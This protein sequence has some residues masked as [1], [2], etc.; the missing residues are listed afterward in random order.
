MGKRMQSKVVTV[1][2]MTDDELDGLMSLIGAYLMSRDYVPLLHTRKMIHYV[3]AILQRKRRACIGLFVPVGPV[4]PGVAFSVGG[5]KPRTPQAIV[6]VTDLP[7]GLGVDGGPST[8]IAVGHALG[9]LAQGPVYDEICGM[10]A[11]YSESLERLKAQSGKHVVGMKFDKKVPGVACDFC[12][13]KQEII[14]RPEI[15]EVEGTIGTGP[16]GSAH[17]ACSSCGK[18]FEVE[19]TGVVVEICWK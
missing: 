5:K 7:V 17:I 18:T 14:I 19:W 12:G 13:H 1:R 9:V 16:A 10:I 8:D 2:L 6:R 3:P 4:V 11:P 15:T